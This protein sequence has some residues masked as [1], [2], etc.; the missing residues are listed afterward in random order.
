ML[1]FP[2]L[3]PP[4][5][6]PTVP[7]PGSWHRS[8]PTTGDLTYQFLSHRHCV[9]KPESTFLSSEE[10]HV[11]KS[12]I[13][14]STRPS[15]LANFL[16]LSPTSPFPLLP[17]QSRLPHAQV[18]PLLRHQSSSSHLKPFLIFLACFVLV[19]LSP[20]RLK[21]AL[22]PRH[23]GFHSGRSTL[24]NIFLSPFPIGLKIPSRALKQSLQPSSFP[25]LWTLSG[26]LLSLHQSTAASTWWYGLRPHL[27]WV[28]M[29][30]GLPKGPSYPTHSPSFFR[31]MHDRRRA[32]HSFFKIGH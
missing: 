21:A 30:I 20:L 31:R 5:T 24:I 15:P 25:K 2:P 22:T 29:A 11:L 23:A 10:P 14:P 18:P 9:E 13:P 27:D 1:H 28:E 12:L 6:F 7:V 3:P 4:L 19:S 17:A 26:I 32:A 16:R 8:M